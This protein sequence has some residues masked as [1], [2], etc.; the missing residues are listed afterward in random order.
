MSQLESESCRWRTGLS[1]GVMVFPGCP[2]SMC[3]QGTAATP[4]HPAAFTAL[5]PLN[6]T[7]LWI[8]AL[9]PGSEPGGAAGVG[10]GPKHG[11][12]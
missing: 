11:D 4:R 3:W 1:L 6:C 12:W 5:T 7:L 8:P 10:S 2:G 9:L